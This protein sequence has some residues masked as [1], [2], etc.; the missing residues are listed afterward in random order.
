[1]IYAFKCINL[2]PYMLIWAMFDCRHKLYHIGVKYHKLEGAKEKKRGTNK[3]L[4]RKR[5]KQSPQAQK[6]H[7]ATKAHKLTLS[8]VLASHRIKDSRS[9][10]EVMRGNLLC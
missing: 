3:C 8:I 1:M 6:A 9:L 4:K 2:I 7:M 5:K 10:N